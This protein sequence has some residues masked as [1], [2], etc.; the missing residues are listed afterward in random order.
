M[1]NK[2]T[3][4]KR[5][6]LSELEEKTLKAKALSTGRKQCDIVRELIM[7]YEPAEAPGDKFYDAIEEIRKIGI[8]INQIAYMA[9]AT[10]IVDVAYF[11]E[12][13]DK[14]DSLLLDVK[15]AALEPQK[16][17][18]LNDMVKDMEWM[19]WE[20]EEQQKE[21]DRIRTELVTLMNRC[22]IYGDN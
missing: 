8:N 14:L 10:G 7:G 17:K 1:V 5:F 21:C 12:E 18:E 19:L 2:R 20:T 22:G 16:K 9:N 6:D 15:R 11:K 4:P 13:A 3:R